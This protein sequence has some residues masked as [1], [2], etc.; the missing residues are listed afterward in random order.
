MPKTSAA[1]A[2]TPT[3]AKAATPKSAKAKP[4]L[5]AVETVSQIEAAEPLAGQSAWATKAGD[6]AAVVVRLD[7]IDEDPQINPRTRFD[8][9]PL[10]EL[11]A[12][13]G[14]HGVL[15]PILVRPSLDAG[16]YR[17][18]C[19]ARRTRASIKAGLFTIPAVVRELTD[20][21][22][23]DLAAI[24][25]LQREDLN[26]MEK[27]RTYDRMVKGR[28]AEDPDL[29]LKA[30]KQGVADRIRKHIRTVELHLQLLDLP[31]IKAVEIEEGKTGLKEAI[32]WKRKQPVPLDL[33]ADCWLL[34]LE[35]FDKVCADPVGTDYYGE[36][37][38]E[39][40]A[41]AR[42]D[43]G[44]RIKRLVEYPN[45]LLLTVD[46]VLDE[47]SDVT[48]RFRI[49]RG[50][51]AESKLS[52]RF[53]PLT[54]PSL[55][56]HA[57]DTLRQELGLPRLAPGYSTPWL[58]GP[59][60][61]PD[62]IKGE[63][64]EARKKNAERRAAQAAQ[65]AA[66]EQED[67]AQVD[68]RKAEDANRLAMLAAVMQLEADASEAVAAAGRDLDHPLQS[69]HV[70]RDR[71]REIWAMSH[72]KGPWQVA[73]DLENRADPTQIVDSDGRPNA[74]AGAGLEA[75][76][77]LMVLALNFTAGVAVSSGPLFRTPWSPDAPAPVSPVEVLPRER[78]VQM[79]ADCLVDDCEDLGED[80]AEAMFEASR[81][82]GLGLDAFLAQE[83]VE[84]GGDGYDWADDGA[85]QLAEL[86]RVE[87]LGQDV[88][89]PGA[90]AEGGEEGDLPDY[91]TRLAGGGA[92]ADAQ[93]EP[94]A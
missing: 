1:K 70:F 23:V 72:V 9:E 94:Q 25:N 89:S 36:R 43:E 18:V 38:T 21:Q 46:H 85:M 33:P 34:A 88:E 37:M 63:I 27:A 92:Q 65:K 30:A 41:D 44:G 68:A 8:D 45:Q 32:E 58:N 73:P 87:G 2:A 15:Q 39:C 56:T 59:F 75:R 28:M 74:D 7:L 57:L 24:E 17:I 50:W 53:G 4:A 60:E 66:Q 31:P 47:N 10:D 3:T 11:V 20:V 55:R 62:A 61:C 77:R 52:L 79:V 42:F 13:I 78:F 26:P 81:R 12:S 51:D 40:H 86:V 16:R 22:A 71:F 91:L 49:G 14:D 35:V 48:G 84:Y 54:T 5:A 83:G 80:E 76:R 69:E 90:P 67:E 64:A 82:A 93:P 29:S 19:G 6:V